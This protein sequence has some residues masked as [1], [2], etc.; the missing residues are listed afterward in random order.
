MPWTESSRHEPET[1]GNRAVRFLDLDRLAATALV[2]RPFDHLI[3]PGF[4]T[5]EGARAAARSFP[6]LDAP[7]SYPAA[8]LAPDERFRALLDELQGREMTDAVSRK[9]GIELAGRPTMVTLRGRCA[10]G[11]GRIHTDSR[12]KLVTVLIYANDGW[13]PDG[14]RLRLLNG[15]DDIED[16]FAEVSPEAGTM[17]AFRRGDNSFHGHKPHSGRRRSIQLNWVTHAGV[18][19]RELARHRVSAAA[20]R[21]K[22]RLRFAR[23]EV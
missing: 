14:G 7:G 12:T 6:A 20:K 5:P 22:S 23:A 4:L 17:L 1:R 13:E 19:R 3:L 16:C 10:A 15:P 8:A 9:F 18:V 21:L 2:R 11:D